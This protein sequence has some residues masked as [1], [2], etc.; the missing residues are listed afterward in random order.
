VERNSKTLSRLERL[1]QVAHHVDLGL[2]MSLSFAPPDRI[3]EQVEP[4]VGGELT[5]Q[6]DRLT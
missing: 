4:T 5:V 2:L 1:E 3:V 6:P